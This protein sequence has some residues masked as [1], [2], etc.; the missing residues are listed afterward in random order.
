MKPLH[1]AGV[2]FISTVLSASGLADAWTDNSFDAFRKGEF[3]DGGSN[4]YVSASGRV[5]MINRWDLNGDGFLDIVMPSGHAHTEKE[6]TYSIPRCR[7]A[8][9]HGP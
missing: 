2:L 4:L 8:A 1:T 7:H 3:L 9:F 6:D 5:Q